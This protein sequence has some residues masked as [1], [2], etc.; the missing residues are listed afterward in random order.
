MKC[1]I[2][3]WTDARTAS[4]LIQPIRRSLDSCK[5]GSITKTTLRPLLTW[6]QITRT[7]A[8]RGEE[9]REIDEERW[10]VV[11]GGKVKAVTSLSEWAIY[12]TQTRFM[13]CTSYFFSCFAWSMCQNATSIQHISLEFSP[14]CYLMEWQS[15]PSLQ[16]LSAKVNCLGSIYC[17]CQPT[18]SRLTKSINQSNNLTLQSHQAPLLQFGQMRANWGL[19][20]VM[21]IGQ[22]IKVVKTNRITHCCS[23]AQ[24]WPLLVA[25]TLNT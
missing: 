19:G 1:L 12:C 3:G 15:Q 4:Q 13:M 24:C 7:E 25:T 23:V 10:G 18:V 16:Y 6:W 21:K 11:G 20:S 22:V 8:D 2:S 5:T 9:E 17:L 14:L